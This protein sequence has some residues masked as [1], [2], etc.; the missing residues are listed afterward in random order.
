MNFKYK[1]IYRNN[2]YS[3]FWNFP[4]KCVLIAREILTSKII[5]LS[6]YDS[7]RGRLSQPLRGCEFPR[8][9]K[10]RYIT[11]GQISEL[12]IILISLKRLKI[13][14]FTWV[15]NA[16][17]GD[18]SGVSCW[19]SDVTATAGSDLFLPSV[20]SEGF[21]VLALRTSVSKR[22]ESSFGFK[23]NKF[24]FKIQN[25]LILIEIG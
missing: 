3:K 14:V 8:I 19:L 1:F 15:H 12:S 24:I 20:S 9:S 18:I 17:G 11:N 10:K 23:G 25:T 22:K 5:A 6:L 21:G 4:L 16:W 7:T 13:N 2:N